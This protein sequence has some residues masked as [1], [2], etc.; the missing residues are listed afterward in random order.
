[1]NFFIFFNIIRNNKNPP[2]NTYPEGAICSP[3]LNNE[4]IKEV[5]PLTLIYTLRDRLVEN[6]L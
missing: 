1:M 6:L 5:Y 2:N 4:D 3:L